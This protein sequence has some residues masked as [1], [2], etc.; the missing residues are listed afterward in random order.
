MITIVQKHLALAAS[1]FQ[2]QISVVKC[3]VLRKHLSNFGEHFGICAHTIHSVFHMLRS[4]LSSVDFGVSA[5]LHLTTFHVFCH[6]FLPQSPSRNS[7]I[8]LWHHRQH[9]RYRTPPPRTLSYCIS[10]RVIM[11][12]VVFSYA[13]W[14]SCH[15]RQT[16]SVFLSSG[17]FFGA[18]CRPHPC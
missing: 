9:Q 11:G 1:R 7:T 8:C 16:R 12:N 15:V 14:T 3:R 10:T 2:F 6:G 13:S 5:I 17:R 4:Q 18:T